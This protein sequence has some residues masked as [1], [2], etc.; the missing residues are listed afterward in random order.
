MALLGAMLLQ[1]YQLQPAVG[2]APPTPVL[3]TTLK[4]AQPIRLT[5]RRRPAA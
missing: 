3:H 4:S 2:A 1:R 5:L